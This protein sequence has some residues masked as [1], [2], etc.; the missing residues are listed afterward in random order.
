MKVQSLLARGPIGSQPS[1]DTTHICTDAPVQPDRS[2]TPTRWRRSKPLEVRMP[3][4]AE[5][6]GGRVVPAREPR[7]RQS[8]PR[9]TRSRLHHLSFIAPISPRG[10]FPPVSVASAPGGSWGGRCPCLDGYVAVTGPTDWAP[11]P[12]GVPQATYARHTLHDPDVGREILAH[13][14]S[15][16]SGRAAVPPGQRPAPLRPDPIIEG[17]GVRRRAGDVIPADPAGPLASICRC[18]EYMICPL[19]RAN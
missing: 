10:A 16:P 6:H 15:S 4:P 9:E 5:R 13:L 17:R 18:R 8:R 3:R 19:P 14:G 7:P 2:P 12:E 11:A 1:A